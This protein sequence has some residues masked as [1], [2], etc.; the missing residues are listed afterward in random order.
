VEL[1]ETI[2]RYRVIG[3][4][5]QGGMGTV[6]RAQDSS[7]D[8]AV[9]LKL[10][11]VTGD[12]RA[13]ARFLRE[14]RAAAGLQHPNIITVYELGQ[15]AG[16]PYIA[17]ELLDGID[18]QHALEGPL[19]RDPRIA[20]TLLLH[21]LA[22]LGHAHDRGIVHRDVKPSNVF[23]PRRGLPKLL[24][25]GLARRAAGTTVSGSF[26]GTPHYLSPEQVLDDELDGRSDLFSAGL[27]AYELLTGAHAFVA[28][29]LVALVFRIA[30]EDP[31]L[32]ALPDGAEWQRVRQLLLKAL[33]RRREDRYPDAAAFRADVEPVLRAFGGPREWVAP[34]AEAAAPLTQMPSPVPS[35][36]P[37]RERSAPAPAKAA[38]SAPRAGTYIL[39]GAAAA[40]LVALLALATM[41]WL[42]LRSAGPRAPAGSEPLPSP[43]A[44][45]AA[46]AGEDA[47][48][49]RD[50]ASRQ[51]TPVPDRSRPP[52]AAQPGPG[53]R[54]TPL[55]PPPGPAGAP[56]SA[57]GPAGGETRSV[58]LQ[59]FL[60][61]GEAAFERGRYA[62][63]REAALA[64]L[65]LEP[66]SAEARTLLEDAEGALA[67]EQHLKQAN[68]ALARGDRE[69]ALREV[70]AG[71]AI[72]PD[73]GRLTAL[74]R[75][76]SA[77]SGR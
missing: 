16:Q 65:R 35:Q 43:S 38:P 4:L 73:D 1:P 9:A 5:G 7:L 62:S 76:L 44:E 64:A 53:T 12:E 25:F 58:S 6:Y 18:L 51:A 13:G 15:H 56:R 66:T 23:V 19:P 32:S 74:E 10:M 20:L 14:A 3:L 67:V 33:A 47:T 59:V 71:L 31:D 27:V 34:A 57:G 21:V 2:G 50:E 30:H 75:Q 49:R 55:A 52:E 63:A 61:R 29:T 8:R 41:L 28:D 22:G 39:A 54:P 68:A 60:T 36:P 45:A 72:A 24:D 69:A 42:L 17:M 48:R 77:P 26:A 70:R 11:T 46:P 40:G 37:G